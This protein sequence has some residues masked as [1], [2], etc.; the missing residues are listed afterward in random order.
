ML[1]DKLLQ[2]VKTLGSQEI[3]GCGEAVE[4]NYGNFDDCYYAGYDDGER[5]LA[6]EILK[7]LNEEG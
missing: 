3:V 5:S 7:V 1:K 4:G 6:R 2:I